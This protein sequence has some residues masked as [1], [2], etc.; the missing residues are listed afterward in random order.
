MTER[1]DSFLEEFVRDDAQTGRAHDDIPRQ[2]ERAVARGAR[3]D[4]QLETVVPYAAGDM[5]FAHGGQIEFIEECWNIESLVIRVAFEIVRIQDQP[6]SR[7]RCDRVEEASGRE[8]RRRL[9]QQVN[10]VVEQERNPVSLLK[11]ADPLADQIELFFGMGQREHRAGVLAGHHGEAEVLAVPLEIEARE[12][13]IQQPQI[14]F[15][16]V[17]ERSDGEPDA[18]RD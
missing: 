4:I 11:D 1:R 15:L 8:L 5:Q 7:S 9:G 12:E 10:D 17:V 2:R 16:P 3:V 14:T 18:V 6:A 13:F